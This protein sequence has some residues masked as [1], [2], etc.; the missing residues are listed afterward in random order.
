LAGKIKNFTGID[1]PSEMPYRSEI[2]IKTDKQ[3][4]EDS[5]ERILV[6]LKALKRFSPALQRDHWEITYCQQK[7]PN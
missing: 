5:L 6:G 3:S 1:D 2:V 7:R 4:P